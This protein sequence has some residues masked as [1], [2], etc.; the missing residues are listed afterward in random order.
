MCCHKSMS[1]SDFRQV[2]N[3]KVA[4]KRNPVGNKDNCVHCYFSDKTQCVVC[5][6]LLVKYSGD[7]SEILQFFSDMIHIKYTGQR[8]NYTIEELDE[9][10]VSCMNCKYYSKYRSITDKNRKNEFWNLLHN[11]PDVCEQ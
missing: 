11:T 3:M 2:K 9:I 10:Q 4:K 7:P 5:N 6:G 8:T 1:E